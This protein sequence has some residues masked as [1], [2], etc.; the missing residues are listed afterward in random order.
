MAKLTLVDVTSLANAGSAKTTLNNNFT[1]IETA[2]ENTLSRDGTGPNAMQADIDLGDHRLLNVADPSSDADGVNLRS[3]RGLVN[4]FAGEIAETIVMGTARVKHFTA[5]AGQQDFP[6]DSSP[7]VTDNM[8]VY[9]NGIQMDSSTEYT[10]TGSDLKTLHFTTGRVADARITVRYIELAPA[11]GIMRSD[12]SNATKGASLVA[13]TP[14]AGVLGTVKSFLD[15]LWTTGSNLGAALVRWIQTGTGALARTIQ[16][17]LRESVSVEDFGAIGDGISHPVSEW[18]SGGLQ[19]RGYSGLAAIQV[20]FPHVTALTDEIDYAAIQAAIN[21]VGTGGGGIVHF[22]RDKEYLTNKGLIVNQHNVFLQGNGWQKHATVGA[23]SPT[24][25]TQYGGSVI[26]WTGAGG[27]GNTMLT[28]AP[29]VTGPLLMGVGMDGVVLDGNAVADYG[30]KVFSVQHGN[31]PSIL[32][33]DCVVRQ[34]WFDVQPSGAWTSIDPRDNQYIHVGRL[35]TRCYLAG[36]LGSEGVLITGDTVANTSRC[37]FDFV[38]ILH[39]DGTGLRIKSADGIQFNAVLSGRISGGIG[40]GVRIEGG[41]T[42]DVARSLHFGYMEAGPGGLE[43]VTNTVAPHSI[44]IDSY[45]LNNGTPAPTIGV[46]CQVS[47]TIDTGVARVYSVSDATQVTDILRREFNTASTIIGNRNFSARNS[48]NALIDYAKIVGFLVDPTAGSE[49]GRLYFT[50]MV[51]GASTNVG[52]IGAGMVLGNPT[53]GDKGQGTLNLA[54]SS[55]QVLSF[56]GGAGLY[57]GTGS[58]EGVVTAAVGSL[59]LRTD[60]ATSLYVKQTGAGNTGWVAK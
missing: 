57:F 39:K 37:H 9:D 40:P 43:V 51:S 1:A 22:G 58:P 10:L 55:G 42:T 2:L 31:F 48:A 34:V 17:K 26:R 29:P 3:V 5:T 30:L 60:S 18:L 54:G 49:D 25:W 52:Y 50:N 53:G 15:S 11:D 21:A 13:Y 59:F 27:G 16:S 45:S 6:L 33:N 20:D 38:S 24:R 4:Q 41:A 12:L 28:F 32:V 7:G 56:N 46:N 14:P 47:Y 44:V 19:D 35:M 8:E 23:L 36:A